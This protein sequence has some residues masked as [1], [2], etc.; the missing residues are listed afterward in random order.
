VF[1]IDAPLDERRSEPLLAAELSGAW[2]PRLSAAPRLLA[3]DLDA[4][5]RREPSMPPALPTGSML[6]ERA[7]PVAS[8]ERRRRFGPIG[9]LLLHLLPLL[10]LIEWPAHPPVETK[11]IPVRLVFQPPPPHLLQPKPKPKPAPRPRLRTEARPPPGRLASVDMGDTRTKG[12]DRAESKEPARNKEPA[13]TEQSPLEAPQQTAFLPPPPAL[14][15]PPLMTL[16]KPPVPRATPA[17]KPPRK[18]SLGRREPVRRLPEWTRLEARP[19]RFPGPAATRDEYLAYLAYLARQHIGLLTRSLLG[20]RRGETVIDVLV[21]DDGTVAM[22][23]VGQSSGYPDIDARVEDM[24]RAVGR[25]PPL[26]QWFQG[27]RMQLEFRLEFPE[28]LEEDG[29]L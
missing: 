21:L 1:R 27:S 22:L 23:R 16:Q 25:F 8:E 7:P 9:S 11:P 29:R 12:R 5:G 3:V 10:L 28:A 24:I 20:D 14:P 26:P 6:P 4:G 17:P 2:R 18:A 19:A 13:T 15:S